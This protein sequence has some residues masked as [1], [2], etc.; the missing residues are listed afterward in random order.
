VAEYVCFL[1]SF[2]GGLVSEEIRL[3]RTIVQ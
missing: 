3:N 1:I 2:D